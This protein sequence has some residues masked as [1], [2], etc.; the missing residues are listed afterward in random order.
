VNRHGR[1]VEARGEPARAGMGVASFDRTALQ[2][3]LRQAAVEDRD[4]VGPEG[5]QGPP[6]A[7]GGEQAGRIVDHEAH[8]VAQAERRHLVGE[9]LRVGQHMRQPGRD[10][11]DDVDVEENRARN[12]ALAELVGP[13]APGQRQ[14]PRAIDDGDPRIAKMG[15]QP[16]R[17][18]EILMG[19]GGFQSR[20][21]ATL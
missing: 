15:G 5:A 18:D 7:G 16:I 10:V 17:A 14:V 13:D 20:R 3:P 11:G 2:P 9:F 8:A 4:L 21:Y 1:V 19:H 6:H 12:V